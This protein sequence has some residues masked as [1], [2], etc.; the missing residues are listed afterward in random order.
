LM[1]FQRLLTVYLAAVAVWAICAYAARRIGTGSAPAE[2]MVAAVAVALLVWQVRPGLTGVPDPADP[3][4][5]ARGLYPVEHSAQPQQASLEA[6]VRA[7]DA[8][9][10][11][12]TA[13]LVLG[14]AL[15]W[16]EQLWSPL[17]TTR[18]LFFDDWLWYWQPH[19]YGTPGYQPELGNSYPDP[20]NTLAPDYL[21]HHGIGAVVATGQAAA[22][23][24]LTPNLEPLLGGE[25]G[26]WLVRQ[27]TTV[28]TLAGANA[29]VTIGDGSIAASG[30]S[31][32]GEATIRRNWFP[33]WTAT[34]NGRPATIERTADNY[35]T[36]AIPPGSIRVDLR[37]GVD[38]LDWL[39]RAMS[40]AG[41]AAVLAA[42]VAAVTRRDRGRTSLAAAPLMVGAAGGNRPASDDH[43]R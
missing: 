32:G 19:H 33:R 25:Y 28:V 1:P 4:I 29:D 16:H 17:W 43:G 23:A 39:A 11:P 27:P 26:A 3:T 34:V 10:P 13:I 14:T 5:P 35:M 20:L 21:Q 31:A 37:Y 2:F 8:A 7:A 42:L 15:S 40:L 41:A 6:A 9:A 12:G 24:D 18:P 36:V 22:A 38:A 30:T